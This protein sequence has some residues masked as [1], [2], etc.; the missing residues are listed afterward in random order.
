MVTEEEATPRPRKKRWL[1]LITIATILLFALVSLV[2]QQF[3]DSHG[4]GVVSQTAN[5]FAQRMRIIRPLLF[6]IVFC[7]WQPLLGLASRIGLLTGAQSVRAVRNRNR[8]FLWVALLEI[9]VGQGQ[10]VLGVIILV[11]ILVYAWLDNSL[12]RDHGS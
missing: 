10:V 2:V 11:S 1:L 7:F 4:L 3:A 6:F 5:A 12:R 8:L 9:T